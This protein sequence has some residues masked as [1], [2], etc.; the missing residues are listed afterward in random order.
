ML[1]P[2]IGC[3]AHGLSESFPGRLGTLVTT[4]GTIDGRWQNHAKRR[5]SMY[6]NELLFARATD[7]IDLHALYQ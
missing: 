2:H 5:T 7:L 6:S 3:E 4:V 1:H